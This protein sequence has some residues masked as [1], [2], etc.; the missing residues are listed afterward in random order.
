[1]TRL[2][3]STATGAVLASTADDD[4]PEKPAIRGTAHGGFQ[5]TCGSLD[6]AGPPCPLHAAPGVYNAYVASQIA[7]RHQQPDDDTPVRHKTVNPSELVTSP[8]KGITR[9]SRQPYTTM[10]PAAYDVPESVPI[11]P[12]VALAAPAFAQNDPQPDTP[13]EPDA[14]DGVT[15]VM[16]SAELEA[17]PCDDPFDRVAWVAER[18]T[19][20]ADALGADGRPRSAAILHGISAGMSMGVTP[21][22]LERAGAR[23]IQRALLADADVADVADEDLAKLL[24]DLAAE[25]LIGIDPTRKAARAIARQLDASAAESRK[26][27][28]RCHADGNALGVE[29]HNARADALAVQ[30]REIRKAH[31]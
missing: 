4:A 27:A 31:R 3:P 7:Q 9:P 17:A 18:L 30:A 25:V 23:L 16:P 19:S 6:L 20:C 5:C 15:T 21:G 10:L 26:T 22:P 14:I 8:K 29:H 1:L 12:T 13:V 28:A 24:M 2:A 11:Q